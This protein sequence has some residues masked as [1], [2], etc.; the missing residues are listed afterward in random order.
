MRA[1]MPTVSSSCTRAWD[2]WVSVRLNKDGP[3]V[4]WEPVT[5]EDLA[6]ARCEAWLTGCLRKGYLHIP[7][8]EMPARLVPLPTTDS[9]SCAG[10]AIEVTHPGGESIRQV[11][12]LKSLQHVASRAAQRLVAEGTLKP[13]GIYFFKLLAEPR[14]SGRTATVTSAITSAR[15]SSQTSETTSA[16]HA[17]TPFA[18][19]AR[20]QPLMALELPLDTV[21]RLAKPVGEKE[22]DSFPVFYT[23]KAFTQAE[24]YSRLG[25][26][27]HPPVETG[28]VLVGSLCSCPETGEL[29]TVVGDALEARDAEQKE[30]S[31]FYSSQSWARIQAIMRGRQTQP[32]TR[33]HRILG[34]AHGH[35]FLPS[36]QPPCET[37]EKV[38][39]C[40]R[41]SVFVSAD[42]HLWSR[43]V[44]HRQPW[45]LCHIFGLTA[46]GEPVH[47]LFG[48][49]G[50]S[51][52]ERG[53]NV[54][55]DFDP[56]VW[57]LVAH[58]LPPGQRPRRDNDA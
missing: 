6:D 36:N 58:N 26:S 17:T 57:P 22:R 48:L 37:C 25:A 49:S 40:R 8:E 32:P 42:D 19:V 31:L 34:Q 30:F 52:V 18:M 38:N 10:F 33:S 12:S 3:E 50:G 9:L 51:L 44:F 53:F 23:E 11:F 43:A 2:L 13:N 7:L 14:P 28:A 41:T 16:T 46:R 45:H 35:N 54:I 24:H 1:T 20:P 29:F 47:S 27:S 15:T 4:T 55:P 39:D 5:E 56:S 21:L